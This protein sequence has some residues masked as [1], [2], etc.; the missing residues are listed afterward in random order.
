VARWAAGGA[1]A[2]VVRTPPLNRLPR[3]G[4]TVEAVGYSLCPRYAGAGQSCCS[5]QNSAPLGEALAMR[6]D[7]CVPASGDP[8]GPGPVTVGKAAVFAGDLNH[9]VSEMC[10][11][12][13][14]LSS[15]FPP[16]R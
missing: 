12:L 8:T 15:P 11:L 14:P 5:Q 7:H 16:S 13:D 10:S 3:R 2:L 6:G 9:A 1:T 4:P